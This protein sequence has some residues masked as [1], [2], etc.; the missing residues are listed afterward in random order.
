MTLFSKIGRT[1]RN[2]VLVGLVLITPLAVTIFVVNLIFGFLTKNPL[3]RFAS[4]L[5][6]ASMRDTAY[7]A[8]LGRL[9]ALFV[10]VMVLFLIGFFVRSFFGKRL[11]RLA[12]MVVERIPL[13]NKIY[14]WVRQISEAFLA[15]RQTLFKEVVLVQYPRKG[16]YAVA[17]VTAPISSTFHQHLPESK[18]EPFVALFIPTTPN[19]TSGL[20]IVAPRTDLSPLP[21][22]VAEA[23]KLI[24]S[25]GAVFPGE[26]M[27]D[28][29]PTLIDKLEA[30]ITREGRA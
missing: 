8:F 10:A 29:R 17:F 23:M 3:F 9:I 19:P 7:A 24:I 30:W 18:E 2:N 12:E 20:M 11:Y 16:L 22:S 21:I 26:A 25:A 14:I 1:L 5:L 13:I 28:D 6:P 15:Q 27:V 4:D